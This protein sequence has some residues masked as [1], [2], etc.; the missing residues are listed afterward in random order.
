MRLQGKQVG[1]VKA[2]LS[3]WPCACRGT[4]GRGQPGHRAPCPPTRPDPAPDSALDQGAAACVLLSGE[5]LWP[6][7]L[8]GP[9][10]PLEEEGREIMAHSAPTG[11]GHKLGRGG[12][13]G[14]DR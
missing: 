14:L 4:Q 2:T 3:V 12:G 10:K 9:Q 5:L 7:P 13:C 6:A 8:M 1:P 11:P